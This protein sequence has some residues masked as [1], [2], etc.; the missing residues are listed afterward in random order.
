MMV[1]ST[2]AVVVVDCVASSSDFIRKLKLSVHT[3]VPLFSH[4]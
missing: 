3:F 4:L 2:A 1:L